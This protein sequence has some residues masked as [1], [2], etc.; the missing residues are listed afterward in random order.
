MLMYANSTS[1]K[2]S[3]FALKGRQAS[4]AAPPT[5][6]DPPVSP[7]LEARKLKQQPQESAKRVRPWGF[8]WKLRRQ[9]ADS[10]RFP[11]PWS[12]D[13]PDPKLE[14]QCFIV[15]DADGRAL[16]YVYFE[17]EPGWRSAAKMLRRDEASA[18]RRQHRQAAGAIA[19]F[20]VAIGA[21]IRSPCRHAAETTPG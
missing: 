14:R 17:D 19:Q 11:P 12:V 16:A 6:P 15:R 4:R 10:R 18:H 9:R 13:D 2:F 1:P 3:H 20:S 8:F 5:P 7:S 21:V